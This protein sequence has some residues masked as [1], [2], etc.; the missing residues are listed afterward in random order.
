[1]YGLY[2]KKRPSRNNSCNNGQVRQER[3]QPDDVM[4]QT[5]NQPMVYPLFSTPLY[6]NDVGDFECPDIKRLEYTSKVPT[7]GDAPFLSSTDKHVLDRPEF[8]HIHELVMNEVNRYGREVLRVNRDIEFYITN[9]WVNVY[10]PG[11]Q[12]GSHTHNNS[13]FS[14]VLYLKVAEDSGDIIFYRD[15]LSLVPFP[16]ALDLAIDASTIYNCKHFGHSPRKNEVVIF[17]SIVLHSVSQN[18]SNEERWCIAFNV[19][20]RGNIGGLHELVLK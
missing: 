13:L 8:A 11:D 10:R 9:S 18:N 7:G 19:F 2:S 17:P 12:A 3:C 5:M 16:P 4:N 15:I 6:I 1:M 20:V 14:G